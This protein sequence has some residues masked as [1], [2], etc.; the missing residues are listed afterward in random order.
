MKPDVV[1]KTQSETNIK[2][3]KEDNVNVVITKANYM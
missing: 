2:Y 3:I 1:I